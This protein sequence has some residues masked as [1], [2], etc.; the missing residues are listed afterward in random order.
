MREVTP[1]SAA[2]NVTMTQ[3]DSSRTA[4][5][6]TRR[7][8]RRKPAPETAAAADPALD[9][10]LRGFEL[11]SVASHLLRR[12]HFRAEGIFGDLAGQFGITPRQKALLIAAYRSPGA[13]Q[14]ALA[15]QIALD[16]NTFTE[17]LSRMISTGLLRREKDPS[18]SRSNRIFIT[19]AGVEL[20]KQIMPVDRR[21]EEEVFAP[22]PPEHRPLFLECLRRM[23]GVEQ[24]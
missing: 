22:I 11:T 19:E 10:M 24:P 5:T 3:S 13:H 15:A 20:L 1:R 6:G 9:R 18:D 12:A 17:M 14:S 8:A 2:P 21:V 7:A 4:T 23:I 16:R